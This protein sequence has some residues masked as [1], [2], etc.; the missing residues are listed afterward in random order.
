MPEKEG[1]EDPVAVP[2]KGKE[3]SGSSFQ[4]AGALFAR[5]CALA[6]KGGGKS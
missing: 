2:F 4:I 5:L 6:L 1:T 3:R